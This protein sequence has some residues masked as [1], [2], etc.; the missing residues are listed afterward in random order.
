MEAL[1]VGDGRVDVGGPHPH[2]VPDARAASIEGPP[3]SMPSAFCPQSATA[4]PE[5]TETTRA[6]TQSAG[7]NGSPSFA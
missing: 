4:K 7:R 1:V 3:W 5:E 2:E 6:S